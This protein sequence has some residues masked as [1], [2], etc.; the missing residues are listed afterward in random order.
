[1]TKIL[2]WEP[3]KSR[4]WGNARMAN[5][6]HLREDLAKLVEVLQAKADTGALA[7]KADQKRLLELQEVVTGTGQALDALK[8]QMSE[9]E[10]WVD[11]ARTLVESTLASAQEHMAGAERSAGTAKADA[12]LASELKAD[13]EQ[14]TQSLRTQADELTGAWVGVQKTLDSLS[15]ATEQSATKAADMAQTAQVAAAE[16]QSSVRQAQELRGAFSSEHKEAGERMATAVRES[17][18]QATAARENSHLAAAASELTGSLK[19]ECEELVQSFK[20]KLDE[21]SSSSERAREEVHA[22][23]SSTQE[24][25]TQAA[26]CSQA[27]EK[28]AAECQ[29]SIEEIRQTKAGL[30]AQEQQA[31]E[32]MQALEAMLQQVSQQVRTSGDH[33]DSCQRLHTQI[34]ESESKLKALRQSVDD[35]SRQTKQSRDEAEGIRQEIKHELTTLQLTGSSFLRR[36]RWLFAGNRE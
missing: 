21:F 16:C 6:V 15:A 35:F 1:M 4:L 5:I 17:Q 23:S 14:L 26:D 12:E 24:N 9:L 11:Q 32:R 33:L 18:A 10:R 8:R 27:S 34:A 13:C 36:V 29:T 30:Q 22:W 28:A 20:R 3:E 31:C 25:A 2:E 7:A 19:N